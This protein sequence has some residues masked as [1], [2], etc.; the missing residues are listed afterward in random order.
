[1]EWQTLE[2]KHILPDNIGYFFQN[3]P[4]CT[5]FCPIFVTTKGII[6]VET[7]GNKGYVKYP[8]LENQYRV[9][10]SIVGGS[11]DGSYERNLVD[12][13]TDEPRNGIST[14]YHPQNSVERINGAWKL[15]ISFKGKCR[16]CWVKTIYFSAQSA[17]IDSLTVIR[18]IC[19]IRNQIK[20]AFL[21]T[22]VLKAS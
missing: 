13:H 3:T 16:I 12:K 7:S 10:S 20:W 17:L 2:H 21:N 18:L 8:I 4:Y 22:C 1:M 5:F 9:L 15:Q 11:L 19:F 6:K 14:H